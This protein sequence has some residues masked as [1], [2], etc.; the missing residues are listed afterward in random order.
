MFGSA[1]ILKLEKLPGR[2]N[3]GELAANDPIRVK[4]E[5]HLNEVSEKLFSTIN[6]GVRYWPF[7]LVARDL[8]HT[9]SEQRIINELSYT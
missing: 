3:L 4:Q 6:T 7:L 2:H 1:N 5:I 9:K 8:Y